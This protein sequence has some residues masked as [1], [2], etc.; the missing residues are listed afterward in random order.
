MPASVKHA[1]FA[2]NSSPARDT[3]SS[4]FGTTPGGGEKGFIPGDMPKLAPAPKLGGGPEL[5]GG[6]KGKP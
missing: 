3:G 6:P 2:A 5:D 1:M 4:K